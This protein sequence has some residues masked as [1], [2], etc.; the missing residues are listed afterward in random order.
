M[1]IFGVIGIGSIGKRHVKNLRILFP[2]A[3]I[4]VVSSSGRLIDDLPEGATESLPTIAALTELKPCLV[5]ISSPSSFHLQHYKLV[6]ELDVP[7]LIEKPL[8]NNSSNG[9][10]IFELS[11]SNPRNTVAV[12]YCLR[13]LPSAIFVKNLID[14]GEL[15]DVYSIN[16]DV[17]QYLPGWRTDKTYLE[18][19]SVSEELG[20]GVLLELSHELDY[21]QWIFGDLELLCSKLQNTSELN[22]AVEEIADIFLQT[23]S[24]AS[25]FLHMDFIQKK[26]NRTCSVI[27]KYGRLE[28]NLISNE[29]FFNTENN[30]KLLFSQA[31]YDSNNIYLD[32]L[33]DCI[34]SDGSQ[35][36]TGASVLSSI[37]IL[38]IIDD[39][40]YQ[41]KE[42]K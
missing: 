19:V 25:C 20:G 24:G 7:I 23:E 5:I 38:K 35:V 12:G 39:I 31:D 2:S 6:C 14:S 29:V 41:A 22:L 9:Q 1:K 15:G 3:K 42:A 11:G 32:L 18:S 8:A 34:N 37:N 33:Q 13:Y 30:S 40:K 10:S 4:F 26:T 17:G 21:L 28:W 16:A 27:T 36:F